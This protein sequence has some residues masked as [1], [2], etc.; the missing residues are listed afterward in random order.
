MR[1]PSAVLPLFI[2][3]AALSGC[4]S[5]EPQPAPPATAPPVTAPPVTAP[6]ATVPPTTI[7]APPTAAPETPKPRPAAPK[8]PPPQVVA[9]LKEAEAA[10]A[11]RNDTAAAELFDKVLKLD[12]KNKDARAGKVRAAAAAASLKRTFV[13]GLTLVEGAP[14]G[15]KV[16]GFDESMVTVRKAPDTTGR[17]MFEMSPTK[18]RA[19]DAWAIKVYLLNDGRKPIKLKELAAYTLAD[20]RRAGG[21]V[22]LAVE[23][24]GFRERKLV[25][26]AKGTW[27]EGVK[28]WAFEVVVTSKKDD[29]FKNT[30]TW[31]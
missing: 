11:A 31:K 3:L 9:I 29:A 30:L 17:V 1:F 19:G 28:D 2:A 16:S 25:H 24:V 4:G 21:A 15:G 13:A 18:V 5:P 10:Y 27:P 22:P 12:P 20:G 7:A 8:G 14:M 6:P 23:E 26:E